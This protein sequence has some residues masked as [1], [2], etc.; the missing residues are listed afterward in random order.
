M[1]NRSRKLSASLLE[2]PEQ[3]RNVDGAGRGEGGAWRAGMLVSAKHDLDDMKSARVDAIMN[4]TQEVMLA[5]AQVRDLVGTD[6]RSDWQNQP[7]Y[8]ELRQS[9][10]QYGQDNPIEVTPIDP[11]WR[12]SEE[13]PVN[14]DGIEFELITGRRRRAIAKELGIKIKAVILPRANDAQLH[15]WEVLLRRYREN[16][17]RANLSPLEKM[18][19]IG[20][21]HQAWIVTQERPSIRQ[22]A[23]SLGID[24]SF[25]S[26]SIRIFERLK[27]LTRN[28]D[29]PY[30][31]SYREL[32][33][34]IRQ[35]GET[36]QKPS[37]KKE[38]DLS[39]TVAGY[40]ITAKHK[41]KELTLI[42]RDI[43]Y[44]PDANWL[45]DQL[46]TFVQNLVAENRGSTKR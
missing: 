17:H 38:N 29:N 14:F 15:Q 10:T 44:E 24:P 11:K 32:E 2:T 7:E 33:K 25:V 4:G 28:F 34:W 6:R 31:L 18:V 13:N 40:P 16:N 8:L 37:K 5:P 39:L 26:R 9:I 45:Q 30:E 21:M 46:E 12:P 20:E 22:F 27:E 3:D 41:G 19:S 23:H 35:S 1:V 36:S 42:F 43:Y